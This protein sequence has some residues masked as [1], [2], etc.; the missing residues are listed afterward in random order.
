MELSLL[1]VC[2]I[3]C[4]LIMIVIIMLCLIFH[5]RFRAP[6]GNL[7]PSSLLPSQ[8]WMCPS[9]NCGWYPY[10]ELSAATSMPYIPSPDYNKPAKHTTLYDNIDIGVETSLTNGDCIIPNKET[11]IHNHNQHT[12]IKH[13]TRHA[14]E[15]DVEIEMD[16]PG[17]KNIIHRESV[18]T[19]KCDTPEDIVWRSSSMAWHQTYANRRMK[20]PRPQLRVKKPWSMA[21]TTF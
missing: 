16:P 20:L 1:I 3:L 17:V 21:E 7:Y 10:G 6:P 12:E 19:K 5:K 18:T 13:D 14:I 9:L 8:S 2:C 4:L 11:T 15:D